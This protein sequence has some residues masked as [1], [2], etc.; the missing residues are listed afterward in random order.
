MQ[1]YYIEKTSDTSE[2]TLLAVGFASLLSEVSRKVNKP[3]K[4]I[5]IQDAGPYY[6]IQLPIPITESD[7]QHLEPFSVAPPLVT[8]KQTDKQA[9]Q[10]LKLDGFPYQDQQ[11]ISK[12][13][14]EKLRKLPPEY[15][16]PE[17]RLNKS[18]SPLL[19]DIQEPDPKLGHYQ[20]ITQMKI[21]TSYNDLAQRGIHLAQ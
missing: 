12:A 19:A 8:E 3:S 16:T 15:R 13:Y 20:A 2:D 6:E 17:A 10:G 4:G 18:K 21:A 5:V 11:E 14:Y 9:K 1:R 7:L